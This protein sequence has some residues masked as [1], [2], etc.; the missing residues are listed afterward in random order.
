MAKKKKK[1]SLKSREIQ[2]EAKEELEVLAAIFGDHFGLDE[3]ARGFSLQLVPHPGRTEPNYVSAQLAV[4][5]P[6]DYP[7]Q[8]LVLKVATTKGLTASDTRSLTKLLNTSSAEHAREGVVAG[9]SVAD[10]CQEFLL[11]KNNPEAAKIDKSADG[12]LWHS[13]LERNSVPQTEELH[14]ADL[15][16]QAA[17]GKGNH[18]HGVDLFGDSSEMPEAWAIQDAESYGPLAPLADSLRH[19]PSSVAGGAAADKALL[20]KRPQLS[21]VTSNRLIAGSMQGLPE[22]SNSMM[23]SMLTAM[24]SGISAV[25]RRM[26]VNLPLPLR[27][28]L[29]GS[30]DEDDTASQASE[31]TPARRSEREQIKRDLLMGHLLSLA[32]QS[33][34]SGLP[35]HALP[36]LA[37]SLSGKGLMPNWVQWSLTQQPALFN[38]AFE[39]LF[40]EEMKQGQG[41]SGPHRQQDDPSASW[42]LH[43]FWQR[44]SAM[45]SAPPPAALHPARLSRYESDF[46]ELRSLGKGGYGV[47]VSAINRLDGRQYAVKKIKMQ[48]QSPQGFSRLIREVTTLSRLQ[49]P[50]VVRYFQAWCEMGRASTPA[51]DTVGELEG[52]DWLGSSS[53]VGPS[54]GT[55]PIHPSRTFQQNLR[56]VQELSEDIA[57]A[58]GTEE[59]SG[60]SSQDN[61]PRSPSHHPSDEPSSSHEGFWQREP[62]LGPQWDLQGGSQKEQPNH[63]ERRLDRQQQSATGT[64]DFDTKPGQTTGQP[65]DSSSRQGQEHEKQML[66]IQMEFCPRTLKK[67]LVAGPIE[68]ADAWQLVRQTLAGLAHIHSQGIIHRDLKPDNIF[69]DAKGEVKLGDFGLAK[70]HLATDS[71]EDAAALHQQLQPNTDAAAVASE[72]SGVLGTSFYISPEIANGW[73]QY[74]N[75]VDLYSLGVIAFELWHP[76]TTAMERVVVLRELVETG[77]M[78]PGWPEAHPVVAKLVRWLMAANPDDRPSAREVLRSEMLPPTVGDEQLTD[79][80]RSLPDNPV[81]K[82]RVM[83]AMFNLPRM[84]LTADELPGTPTTLQVE[85]QEAVMEG[86][87]E[88]FCLHGATPMA[89]TGVG[90]APLDFPPDAVSMLA[91]DGSPWGLRYDLR[92]P[93]AAW[94]ARQAAL[95]GTSGASPDNLRRYEIAEVRRKARNLPRGHLQADLDIVHPPGLPPVDKMLAEAELIKAAIEVLQLLPNCGAF[96]IRISHKLLLDACLGQCEVPQELRQSALALLSTAAGASPMHPAARPKLWPSIKVALL[97]LGTPAAA[98]AQCKQYVVQIP[99]EAEAGLHKLRTKLEGSTV[100]GLAQPL[101][102]A[103]DDLQTLISYLHAWG[104][105]NNDVILEPLLRPHNQHYSGAIFQVHL[106]DKAETGVTSLVAVGGRYDGLMKAV[107]QQAGVTSSPPPAAVGLTLNADRL[108]LLASAPKAKAPSAIPYLSQADVLVCAKGGGGLLKERMA[109]VADLWG[110]G[111]RAE[112]MQQAAPSL[113][114]QYEYAHLRH[115]PWLLIIH[116]ATLSAADT[117]KVKHLE[118]K[119]GEDIPYSDV[120]RSMYIIK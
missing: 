103:L 47:V 91:A 101:D 57:S 88:V 75:K 89:S 38:K 94:L 72:A 70:F 48:S 104:I 76:F 18:A 68:E 30:S 97:G 21:D 34:P 16:A 87:K 105:A 98:V 28:M 84:H 24:R 113:T 111:L 27:K 93:F 59:V 100:R 42:A 49:H 74:D 8:P 79:L 54:E 116:G 2:E 80:L 115:I 67:I 66:Y 7:S 96:E 77:V 1:K 102:Q 56:S 86:M 62:Q 117:V 85:A 33:S 19:S 41:G 40:S 26:G 119:T 13:M 31:D 29:E 35:A 12:S 22:A 50:H 39:R 58:S 10:A 73:P 114:A 5:Y 4:R 82:D 37:A 32:T 51:S 99:C 61:P 60:D 43:Q 36:A 53:H 45:Q 20:S 64:W 23:N 52:D 15:S 25:G 3:D 118:R 120:A 109:L 14:S 95:L 81:N 17:W 9:F 11:T 46:Q 65:T 107:W 78:P 55:G 83:D 6:A 71:A 90:I 63:A 112:M 92:Y 44:S 106:V 69:Y 110:A 108:T